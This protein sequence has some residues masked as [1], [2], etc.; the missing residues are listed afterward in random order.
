MTTQRKQQGFMDVWVSFNFF[1]L[2]ESS[3]E[4]TI[5]N[6]KFFME[7]SF[8]HKVVTF[9]K[10]STCLLLVFKYV[11]LDDLIYQIVYS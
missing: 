11:S 8:A 7:F 10:L 2:D 5:Q 3:Y 6:C 1:F 4:I 9:V